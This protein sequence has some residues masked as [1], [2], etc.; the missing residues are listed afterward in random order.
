[1]NC[2]TSD[3]NNKLTIYYFAYGSNMNLKQMEECCGVSNFSVVGPAQIKGFALAFTRKSKKWNGGVADL[4]ESD[5]S[6][7]GVCYVINEYALGQLDCREGFHPDRPS[8]ENSYNRRVVI[9]VDRKGSKIENV[10]CYFANPQ[11]S[12]YQPSKEYLDTV[13]RGALEN[14]LPAEAVE[15]IKAKGRYKEAR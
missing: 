10:Y 13:I 9:I 4:V 6:A 15:N 12:F 3:C 1:M 11:N 14:N 5:E 2:K 7:W 8:N